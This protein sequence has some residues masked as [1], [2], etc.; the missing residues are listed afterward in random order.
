MR[1]MTK[2]SILIL[3]LAFSQGCAGIQSG[4]RGHFVS[5]ET[6]ELLQPGTAFP[7]VEDAAIAAL[8]Y[9]RSTATRS[10]SERLYVGPILRIEGG[11]TW[12]EAEHSG[13]HLRA[14]WRP[15]ARV[16]LS[17]DHVATYVIHPRTGDSRVDR[18]NENISQSERRLVDEV[19]PLHRPL[20]LLTPAG[21]IVEYSHGASV[22]EIVDRRGNRKYEARSGVA[23][24][25]AVKP[26]NTA[27][28]V[29]LAAE[30]R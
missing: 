26:G 12:A 4:E 16:A 21:R 9:I 15:T 18:A 6:N 20:F 25:T 13:N 23:S 27:S 14:T 5:N 22:T 19:D 11:Y 2:L 30:I 29:E 7:S 17:P 8:G 10:E 1:H 28:S 3:A 24:L